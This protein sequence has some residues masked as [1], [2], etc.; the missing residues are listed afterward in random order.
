VNTSGRRIAT[1]APAAVSMMYRG[2]VQEK[3]T[4]SSAWV[5]QDPKQVKKRGADKASW[6]V[7]WIDPGGSK[8]GKSCGPG[9]AGKRLAEK[10]RDR[11]TAQL[12]TGTYEDTS[13]MTWEEFRK[14]FTVKFLEG[15]G[16]RNRQE[17]TFALDH[18]E[19][20]VKPKKMEAIS[21]ASIV[22]YVARRRKESGLHAGTLVSPATINKE[23]RHLRAVFRKA[24]K[25]MK[26]LKEVPEFEFLKEPKKLATYVP[27]DHFALLYQACETAVRPVGQPY[28]A[29]DWWRG[30]LITAFMTGWRIG[31][32]L[33]LRR[34]DVDLDAGTALSRAE[35]NKGKR[36]QLIVLHPVV[37]DHISKLP[38]FDPHIFPWDYCYRQL[39]ADL[40]AIQQAAGVKPVGKEFYG[41]HDLRRAFATMNADRLTADALQALMQHQDYQT[42]QRYINMARQLK[43]A[44]HNL[45]VPDLDTKKPTGT[46]G[47]K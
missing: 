19:R 7:G 41:F 18:F 8:R 21:S 37:I 3:R 40:H 20:I 4:M 30:L 2:I 12:V 33:A 38:G 24:C 1:D 47:G 46:E 44:A 26:C 27:P 17:T 15:M 29:A 11:I 10:E 28:P 5:Y 31:A 13:R 25:R 6:Y 34:E 45:F 9:P 35:D 36:D 43:P 16:A 14:D 39:F 23:L 32:L 42:T 22:D